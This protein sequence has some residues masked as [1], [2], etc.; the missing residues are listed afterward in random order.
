MTPTSPNL[1][2]KPV[3]PNKALRIARA[4]AYPKEI[5][6]L[7]AAVIFIISCWQFASILLSRHRTPRAIKPNS[8]STRNDSSSEGVGTPKSR[9]VSIRRLPLAI[10]SVFRIFAFRSTISLGGSSTV[11]LAEIAVVL[12]YLLAILT[13]EFINSE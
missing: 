8:E 7:V 2:A 9:T 5:W 6:Y 4:A 13:W 11:N 3:D 12:G 10:S 1:A